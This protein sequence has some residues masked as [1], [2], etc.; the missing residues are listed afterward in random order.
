[1]NAVGGTAIGANAV[2]GHRRDKRGGNEPGLV[3]TQPNTV[4]FGGPTVGDRRL[5]GIAPG[6]DGSDAANYEQ[7]RAY[8]GVRL[9][10]RAHGSSP[11][12]GARRTGSDRRH[13]RV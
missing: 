7:V 3:A 5:T 4:W 2:R 10:V 1:M 13:R 6:V 9:G 12:L 11:S 8:G